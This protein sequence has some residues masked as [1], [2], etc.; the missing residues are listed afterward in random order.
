ME[1]N[2]CLMFDTI[3]GKC[4]G[5]GC[6]NLPRIELHYLE[7]NI[8]VVYWQSEKGYFYRQYENEDKPKRVSEKD[9]RYAYETYYD[10]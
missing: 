6:N 4:I 9:Y 10:L 2:E 7:D 5:E 8:S 3:K 1:C